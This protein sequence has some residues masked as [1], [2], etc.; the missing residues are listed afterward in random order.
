MKTTALLFLFAFI[1]I[2]SC[3]NNN[4]THSFITYPQFREDFTKGVWH[5]AVTDGKADDDYS[6]YVLHFNTDFTFTISNHEK[7][8]TGKW[9]VYSVDGTDDAPAADI[10]MDLLFTAYAPHRLE[11]LGHH[12]HIMARTMEKIELLNEDTQHP[13]KLVLSRF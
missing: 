4:K 7:R 8:Y 12:Y 11:K 2:I 5:M 10:G 6:Q 3:T 13:E 9:D 1:G